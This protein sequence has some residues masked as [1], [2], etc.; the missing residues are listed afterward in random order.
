MWIPKIVGSQS[1]ARKTRMLRFPRIHNLIQCLFT[2]S[3]NCLIVLSSK[4]FP[5]MLYKYGLIQKTITNLPVLSV[6]S[7]TVLFPSNLALKMTKNNQWKYSI[8]RSHCREKASA[9]DFKD[10]AALRFGHCNVF[11]VQFSNEACQSSAEMLDKQN[12]WNFWNKVKLF[13]SSGN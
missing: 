12:L 13:W 11:F 3:K 2:N 7:S 10:A 6:L 8:S 9:S 1:D 4:F 5:F